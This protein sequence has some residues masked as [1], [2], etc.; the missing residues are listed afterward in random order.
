MSERAEET[1]STL[2]AD[3]AGSTGLY[4]RHGDRAAL[5]A[6]ENCLD[7]LKTVTAECGGQ[8]V[9]TIGDEL[10]AVFERAEDCHRAACE[11]Q[12][13]TSELPPLGA[14][15]LALRIGF[16]HGPAL[17]QNGDVFGDSVNIAARLVGLAK[18]GQ[19]L[20][21]GRT[22]RAG[23]RLLETGARRLG[24]HLLRGTQSEEAVYEVLWQDDS[25]VTAVLSHT[26][27]EPVGGARLCLRVQG[28]ELVMGVERPHVLIGRGAA[29]DLVVPSPKASRVHAHIEWRRDKFILQDQSTNG[30][31]VADDAGRETVLRMEE[32]ALN[33][34]GWIALGAR[35]DASGDCIVEFSCER[36]PL[37][38]DG[39]ALALD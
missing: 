14:D 1:L 33:G 20:T 36:A 3:V 10:M 4:Q 39:L 18:P 34:H 30:T 9:K 25:E 21:S 27:A 5:A 24:S 19:I 26:L 22:V 8:C 37:S 6:I 16:H 35:V 29:N 23:G 15:Y 28:R 2:F 13:R 11:M 17:S 38:L 32:M 12:W 31:Y 7:L